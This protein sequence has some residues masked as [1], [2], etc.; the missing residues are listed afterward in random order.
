MA[1]Y[2]AARVMPAGA[3]YVFDVAA[4]V[5]TMAS[6]LPTAMDVHETSPDVVHVSGDAAGHHY[7]A[8]GLFR[9]EK[10]QLRVEW[11]SRDT[12]D[13]AGWLQVSH[14]GDAEHEDRSSEVTL[15]LSFFGHQPQ[16]HRGHA[17][18]ETRQ[19]LDDALEK[20]ELE[21]AR[22]KALDEG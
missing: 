15:H 1:E 7:E 3:E 5:E 14:A 19:G 21:V 22:R 13:Y 18:D 6:W 8:D 16:S 2:E 4:D 11:G 17:A 9:A 20:L 10:D 12:P